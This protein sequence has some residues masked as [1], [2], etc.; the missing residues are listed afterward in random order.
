MSKSAVQRG[1]KKSRA[2]KGKS[3][4]KS[5]VHSDCGFVLHY[6]TKLVNHK[7]RETEDRAAVLYS[8]ESIS[9]HTFLA[10]PSSSQV[11]EKMLRQMF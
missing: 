3:I 10:F 1:R 5:F 8:G 4:K 11:L 2:K 7:G 6:D 9:S